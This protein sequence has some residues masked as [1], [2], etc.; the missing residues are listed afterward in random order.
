MATKVDV[1]ET[2]LENLQSML[3]T[4]A[5]MARTNVTN[6]PLKP[7]VLRKWCDTL[8]ASHDSMRKLVDK[9]YMREE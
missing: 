5:E 1:R 2:M 9:S 6:Y 8:Y 7:H 4:V 3:N